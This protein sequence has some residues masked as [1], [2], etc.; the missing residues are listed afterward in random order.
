MSL[1]PVS[2]IPHPLAKEDLMRLSHLLLPFHLI[3]KLVSVLCLLL[4]LTVEPV[5]AQGTTPITINFDDLADKTIVTDQYLNQ[6]GVKFS[7]GN[8]SFPLHTQQACN[9][10][11]PIS[12]PNFV[13]TWPD[14][15]GQ[16]F[17]EFTRPVSNLSFVIIASDA[18][19]SQ[20][21]VLDV[22]RN[23]TFFSS[24]NIFGNGTANVGVSLGSTNSITKIVVRN[25]N[26]AAGVGFDNFTFT[27]PDVNITNPRV[28][29]NLNGTTQNALIGANVTLTANGTPT[30]GT[31]S[32]TFTGSPTI[33][34]GAA[35]RASVGIRWTQQS[36]F[37][38]TVTYTKDGS[39]ATSFVNVNNRM[40]VLTNFMASV[41]PDQVNRDQFCSLLLGATFTLACYKGVGAEDG[42]VWTSTSQIPSVSYLSDPAQSGIKFVQAVSSYRKQL[43]D[44]N[45][46]CATI[47]NSESD[48]YSGWQLDSVVTYN[49]SNHPPRYFSQGNI[50]TMNDFDAP[51][52]TIELNIGTTGSFSYDAFFVS[53]SFET[54]V[55]YFTVANPAQPDPDHPVFQQA[56]GLQGSGSPFARL[57][58]DWGG[59][60]RF[61][62]F[63]SPV[64]YRRELTTT[65]P[66]GRVA[67]GTDLLKSMV[68]NVNM[69]TP[70]TCAGTNATINPID[71]SRYYVHQLYAD[72]LNR[73]PDVNGWNFWRSNITPCAFDMTCVA[74]KRIDV[75]RAFFYSTDFI[76]MHPELGN[77]RGTHQYNS[78]FVYW[79]YRSFLRREPNAPPDNNWEGFNFWVGILDSTNPDAGDFKY[80]EMIR[81][82]LLS[83]EYRDRFLGT[84]F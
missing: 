43:R 23:G 12:P 25:I 4:V 13:C 24:F 48:I 42:I 40:P 68:T 76:G 62:Y 63:S 29:G 82:F 2:R 65:T 72:F 10:C 78:D 66:G 18:F 59:L 49:H 84:P 51:G 17:V 19:F 8:L 30:G 36:T 39:T 52:E 35:N 28:S 75:A 46:E 67:N 34:T 26:D 54:Y 14:L 74:A 50:L 69:L 73:E 47:R 45:I 27:L 64:L 56:I 33:V 61:D 7:S 44:G 31:Y 20:F 16:V 77:P 83:N 80:N 1:T 53:E 3:A 11:G 15:S 58:W 41:S 21:A 9:F 32:W 38:A 57:A 81:A 5:G 22:Y 70:L 37:K 71:S 6:Y 60:V 55:F 79:C